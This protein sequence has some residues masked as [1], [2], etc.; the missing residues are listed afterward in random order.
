VTFDIGNGRFRFSASDARAPSPGTPSARA[1]SSRIG[2]WP[3]AFEPELAPRWGY[4]TYNCIPASAGDDFSELDI[5]VARGLDGRLEIPAVAA[6]Q[7]AV[8]RASP[9]LAQAARIGTDFADL[10]RGEL[11]DDPPH[12]TVGWSLTGAWRQMMATP[13]VGLALTHKVLHHKR[14]ALFPMLDNL[15]AP[16]LSAAPEGLNAWQQIHAEISN[17]RDAF[18]GLHSWFSEKAVARNGAAL[19]LPRLHDIFLWLHAAG[20]WGDAL[21]AGRAALSD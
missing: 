1:S 13:D 3:G 10:P 17:A 5:L 2:L 7:V 19:S 6:L 21:A 8:R 14:P 4:R 9:W 12:G 16:K 20:Q 18:E 15:T 11:A